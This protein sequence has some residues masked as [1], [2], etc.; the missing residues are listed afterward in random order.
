[1]KTLLSLKAEYKS[2][3]GKDWKPG[4]H[5]S[6]GGQASAAGNQTPAA[7]SGGGASVVDDLNNKIT[8]QGDKVRQLKGSKADKVGPLFTYKAMLCQTLHHN[9]VEVKRLII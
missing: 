5:V 9:Y 8:A 6:A 4:Q 2:A 7:G 1:M 3:T